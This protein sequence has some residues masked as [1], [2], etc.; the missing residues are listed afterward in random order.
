M[1]TFRPVI[2][3]LQYYIALNHYLYICELKNYTL[4]I[5]FRKLVI[6]LCNTPYYFCELFYI[7]QM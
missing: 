7:L 1:Y 6:Y 3:G 4:V 2:I 5:L